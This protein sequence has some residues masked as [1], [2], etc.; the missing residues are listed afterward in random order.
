ML[1][2]VLDALITAKTDGHMWQL[3][4]EAACSSM[5]KDPGPVVELAPYIMAT[6]GKVTALAVVLA[7]TIPNMRK[8]MEEK[9]HQ[10]PFTSNGTIES[11]WQFNLA[12]ELL[13]KQDN[14]K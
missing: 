5:G 7:V 14:I 9:V 11:L 4:A 13:Y 12:I 8:E 1:G 2:E 10:V 6:V 3:E